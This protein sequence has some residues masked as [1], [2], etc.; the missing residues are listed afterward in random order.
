[1]NWQ[2]E[3]LCHRQNNLTHI[4]SFMEQHK[5]NY[6]GDQNIWACFL[7]ASLEEAVSLQ[8]PVSNLFPLIWY[9]ILWASQPVPTNPVLCWLGLRQAPQG[10]LL[11]QSSCFTDASVL[12]RATLSITLTSL[13]MSPT[14]TQFWFQPTQYD[15]PR[16]LTQALSLSF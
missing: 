13:S 10:H 7:F 1:M 3:V 14:N 6:S 12:L 16:A 9:T 2:K 5:L 8:N 11:F 15:Y 4:K